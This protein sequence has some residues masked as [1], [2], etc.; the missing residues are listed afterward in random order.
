MKFSYKWLQTYFDD[1]LPEVVELTD[2][3]A[4]HAFEVEGVVESADD[5]V[6]DIDVLPNRASDS[7]SHRGIAR[8]IATLTGLSI[9]DP[10]S[11]GLKKFPDSR[12]FTAE[13]KEAF[14]CHRFTA[15][16][17]NNVKVTSSPSWLVERIES[18][19]QKSI[20]N[21]VDATNY[22][23]FGLGQPIHAF[24]MAKLQEKNGIRAIH[25]RL[26]K[27]GE[28][29]EL[30]GGGG[31]DAGAN[32]LLIV[33]GNS[34][35]PI[36]VAG[37]KGGKST[38]VS[39]STTDVIIEA[40]NFDFSSV[41]KSSRDLRLQTDASI[42]FQNALS[43]ELARYGL[44]EVVQLITQ[45]AGGMIEGIVDIYPRRKMS[46]K[47][48]VSVAEV[49]GLLGLDLSQGRIEEILKRFGFMYDKIKP[50]EHILNI[51]PT[52]VGKKYKYGASVSF[53]APEEFDCSGMINYL[54]RE[55][56]VVIPRVSVDQFV[57]GT[58]IDKTDLKA[59]DVV[60]ARTHDDNEKKTFTSSKNG[61]EEIQ[62]VVHKRTLEHMPGTHVDEGVDHCGLYIGDGNI[63]HTSSNNKVVV[64]EKLEDSSIIKN[65]IGYRRMIEDKDERF[66][67]TSSFERT[68]LKIKEDL[69]EE[70]GRVYGYDK[71]KPTMLRPLESEP[72]PDKKFY[73]SEKIRRLLIDRGFSEV[74]TY[75][76]TSEGEIE[77]ENPL[78][79]E[80]RFLRSSLAGQIESSLIRNARSAPLL[81]SDII[82][83]FEIGTVFGLENKEHTS[84]ALGL[85]GVNRT[86][87][88]ESFDDNLSAL[89]E[90][91]GAKIDWQTTQ[92][93]GEVAEA[94]LDNVIDKLPQPESYD[95]KETTPD[96]QFKP[97]SRYPFVL[98]DIALWVAEGTEEETVKKVISNSAGELLARISLFDVFKKGGKVSYA[99]HLVFQSHKKTLSDDEVNKVMQNVTDEV[100][101]HDWEE[102]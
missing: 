22:V 33:D 56:G 93:V 35:V 70:I 26:G 101:D 16:V 32:N 62:N 79:P 23:M 1:D 59:G 46:R 74:F 11:S 38:D 60:F 99:Y 85:F 34:D 89:N 84:V 29:I 68:D 54:F 88:I 37:I 25:V 75:S 43:P 14:L 51:A 91:L 47:V 69:I 102:R 81:G 42:R 7:L 72:K 96:I 57:F 83:I 80:K 97:F 24:D 45:I 9:N 17:I 18:I 86:Q 50:L 64:M 73:Y 19:G 48:G 66:V 3:L 58:P 20:N 28:S 15:A 77:L 98:R 21:I 40:A 4:L 44:Q 100:I 78:A 65:I 82:K 92:R 41:R 87:D 95:E 30:L 71:V 6:I 90:V 36:A 55:A 2:L 67:I 27:Q 76:F 61:S 63:V 49:N 12:V 31:Y 5:A 53:D 39:L 94:N 10:L 8:E 52:L 13:I